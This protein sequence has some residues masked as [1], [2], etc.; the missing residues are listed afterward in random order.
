MYLIFLLADL[1]DK[2]GFGKFRSIFECDEAVLREDIFEH[3]FNWNIRT[4]SELLRDLL[5]V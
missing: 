1:F 2:R 5:V 3:F 4:G